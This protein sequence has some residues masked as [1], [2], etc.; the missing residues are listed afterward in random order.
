MTRLASGDAKRFPAHLPNG[1]GHWMGRVIQRIGFY[2][3]GPM[4]LLRRLHIGVR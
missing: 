3:V 2:A 4:H 1:I